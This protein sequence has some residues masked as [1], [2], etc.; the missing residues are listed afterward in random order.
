MCEICDISR[1]CLYRYFGSTKEIFHEILNED[2]E[3]MRYKLEQS[4]KNNALA[5][6]L[7]EYFLEQQKK[8]LVSTLTIAEKLINNQI[9]F[10]KDLVIK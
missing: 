4:I 10:L 8:T 6:F 5:D 9:D 7:F 3:G 2:K 1:G